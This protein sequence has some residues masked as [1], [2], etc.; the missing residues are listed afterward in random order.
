MGKWGARER[1]RPPLK[2]DDQFALSA[3]DTPRDR[4]GLNSEGKES[5]IS[6][7]TNEVTSQQTRLPTR[8]A[9]CGPLQTDSKLELSV[10]EAFQSD[11]GISICSDTARCRVA[12]REQLWTLSAG[13]VASFLRS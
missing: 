8:G 12:R 7:D 5:G 13:R 1:E 4:R 11:T 9:S 10:A 2:T 6:V 3:R